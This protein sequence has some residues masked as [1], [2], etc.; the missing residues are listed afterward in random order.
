MIR[1][2]T[3]F[4]R[5]D[6]RLQGA[7][8]AWELR[9]VNHRYLELMPRLPDALR[10]LENAAR[11]RCRQRLGR[12]KVDITLRYQP[13]DTDAELELN[14]DLVKRLSEAAPAAA[15]SRCGQLT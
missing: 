6:R 3:A 9:S 13:D 5:A 8:L 10:G 15:R 1:S 2:M 7:D 14:E 4:A 11:E 12:G